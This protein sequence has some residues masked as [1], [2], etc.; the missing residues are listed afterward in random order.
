M[1]RM[2]GVLALRQ[3]RL[4]CKALFASTL[5]CTLV[6]GCQP[7]RTI[8]GFQ[9]HSLDA[10]RN[11]S[12]NRIAD[13]IIGHIA[14]VRSRIG[15]YAGE[16][17]RTKEAMNALFDAL[18]VLA[19]DN[20]DYR[21][22]SSEYE[23]FVLKQVL[24]PTNRPPVFLY[25]R[26]THP[27]IAEMPQAATPDSNEGY[28]FIPALLSRR[29]LAIDPP[30]RL[31]AFCQRTAAANQSHIV[32]ARD[33]AIGTL[34]GLS[35]WLEPRDTTASR[36][37]PLHND[38][39]VF[40]PDPLLPLSDSS[41]PFDRPF[42]VGL[43]DSSAIGLT[44]AVRKGEVPPGF[45]NLHVLPLIPVVSSPDQPAVTPFRSNLAD[46]NWFA[47]R[48]CL[49]A[50]LH[51]SPDELAKD[52]CAVRRSVKN[53]LGHQGNRVRFR[54]WTHELDAFIKACRHLSAELSCCNA[55]ENRKQ[56]RLT[57]FARNVEDVIGE[58]LLATDSPAP[59]A[60]DAS[61]QT[62]SFSFIVA[63]D[64]QF[65]EAGASIERFVNCVNGGPCNA[66]PIGDIPVSEG[67]DAIRKAKFVLLAGDL[68]D[69][70]AGNAPHIF[71]SNALGLWP[72]VSPYTGT[73]YSGFKE[74]VALKRIF[75]SIRK[76]VFAVPGNHD[77]MV[78]YGGVL[79]FPL[80]SLAELLNEIHPLRDGVAR[81]V[82][83]VNDFI[84]NGIKLHVPT[85]ASMVP[86]QSSLGQRIN[87]SQG[88][89]F[90]SWFFAP[91]YDGLVEWRWHLGPMNVAFQYRGCT[92]VGL[93]SFNLSQPDREGVGAVV[94]NWGGGVRAQDI[95][96]MQAI[97]T[98][99]NVASQPRNALTFLFMHHDPRGV[100]PTASTLR[101]ATPDPNNLRKPEFDAT[102]AWG[103]Y[104][105]VGY[106]GLGY[107]PAWGFFIP[108]IT[109]GCKLLWQATTTNNRFTQ[110]WMQGYGGSELV[111]AITRSLGNENS[112]SARLF[113]GHND[114]PRPWQV[115]EA[116]DRWC[117]G[118]EGDDDRDGQSM[119][120]GISRA[121]LK[122]RSTRSLPSDREPHPSCHAP[123]VEV[124][125]VDDVGNVD[126]PH[127]FVVIEV[128]PVQKKVLRVIPVSLPSGPPRARETTEKRDQ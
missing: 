25:P 16:D 32:R 28:W 80:D 94:E 39:R 14:D 121:F 1:A 47:A 36:W 35:F 3:S 106:A 44:F 108:L 76:P 69:A 51:S 18:L 71:L 123:N 90:L 104:L 37:V 5:L 78:G 20:P 124:V 53:F 79:S 114:T 126:S 102:D 116:P 24:P 22:L 58:L 115:G 128:D 73:P 33:Q 105:T 72:P 83:M 89:G 34:D 82:F 112:T 67:L 9:N 56:E 27:H 7:T 95:G 70:A 55:D 113:F 86:R 107:S 85:T 57:H 68:A 66:V 75:G 29:A 92:F 91:R 65:H 88:D 125:R 30:T 59:V 87:P 6:P 10:Y 17:I 48:Q 63:A 38:R 26:P 43:P 117:L 49:R 54:C 99:S 110:E 52:L 81:G 15:R 42:S 103:N 97:L 98:D 60:L 120:T 8:A 111:D 46:G 127:G 62:S 109:P 122:V 64:F 13:E 41:P 74:H 19:N 101:S 61:D 118:G 31:D 100:T 4:R 96:W 2:F 45:Y 119:L 93:N 11:G 23:T 77:G 40:V 50:D 84:P 21:W 12:P